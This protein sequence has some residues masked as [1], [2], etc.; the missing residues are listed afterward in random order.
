MSIRI[1]GAGEKKAV[2]RCAMPTSQNRD[3][4]HPV[5]WRQRGVG[6]GGAGA[7]DAGVDSGGEPDEDGL[8]GGAGWVSGGVSRASA[9]CARSE[10]GVCG[11]GAADGAGACAARREEF[12]GGGGAV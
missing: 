3:M 10:C 12:E 7:G 2:A 8:Y 11:G 9:G 6:V 5:L 4:G 1:F